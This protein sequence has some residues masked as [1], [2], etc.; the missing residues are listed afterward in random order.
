MTAQISCKSIDNEIQ[1]L[2]REKGE[3]QADLHSASPSSKPTIISQIKAINKKLESA[4]NRLK[5]C[6]EKQVANIQ[7]TVGKPANWNW[8]VRARSGRNERKASISPADKISNS[9]TLT[10]PHSGGW[11]ADVSVAIK[12]SYLVRANQV[13]G[14]GRWARVKIDLVGTT[15]HR[16]KEFV[17]R[18]TIFEKRITKG[19]ERGPLDFNETF[20]THIDAWASSAVPSL[21][22]APITLNLR[23][24]LLAESK[25]KDSIAE[26]DCSR[27]GVTGIRLAPCNFKL[28]E[29]KPLPGEQAP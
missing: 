13:A 12:G 29:F 17:S 19:L 5:S 16:N 24:E 9:Y 10:V 23:V 2:I 27:A 26:L 18:R 22:Y 6:K 21:E 28:T 8:E 7:K 1:S 15:K 20:R 11:L 14:G 3:L 25:W 4:T